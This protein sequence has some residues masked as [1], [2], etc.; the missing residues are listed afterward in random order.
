MENLPQT[1]WS[2]L[3]TPAE[4]A[5]NHHHN[6]AAGLVT[7]A[8]F[9]QK[10]LC[11]IIKEGQASQELMALLCAPTTLKRRT[12][13]PQV[14]LP[15]AQQQFTMEAYSLDGC[16]LNPGQICPKTFTSVLQRIQDIHMDALMCHKRLSVE[17]NHRLPLPWEAVDL[18][19]G[20]LFFSNYTRTH[21]NGPLAMLALPSIFYYI[22]KEPS[23]RIFA[24]K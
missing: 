8:E 17:I 5:T 22:F 9:S 20:S 15:V 24:G 2:P 10:K 23:I 21:L 7:I 12:I 11:D 3:L 1:G 19:D 18:C 14:L 4:L 6:F 13:V 16:H